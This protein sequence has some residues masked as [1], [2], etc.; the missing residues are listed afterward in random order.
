MTQAPRRWT[1]PAWEGIPGL[2]HGFFG[3]PGGV[4]VGA[5]TSLNCSERVG[6]D[7]E[8]VRENRHRALSG[9]SCERLAVPRQVHGDAIAVFEA[10]SPAVGGADGVIVGEPGTAAGV[11]TADC[12]PLLFVIPAAR[13]VAA[14]HAGWKGTA[15][16]IALRAVDLLCREGGGDAGSIQVGLGPA[17][18]GCCYQ[19]G[20]EVV[21]SMEDGSGRDSLRIHRWE[22]DKAWID[23]REVNAGLLR[24]AG[25][26]AESIHLVGPCTRCNAAEFFSHRA[27]GGTTGRQ[28]SAIGWQ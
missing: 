4:S 19:V 27:S 22:G 25:V 1:I 9:L 26:P 18:G 6:D 20:G 12:V 13:L 10:T 21:A 8:A 11:L 16:G 17:I 7:T 15:L 23:L 3:R 24:K 2:V 14:V 5:F 28:L